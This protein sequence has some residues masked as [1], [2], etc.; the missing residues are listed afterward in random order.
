[1]GGVARKVT[2]G[3]DGNRATTALVYRAVDD[4]GKT[5]DA[6]F[7]GVHARLDM[8]S[9]LPGRVDGLERTLVNHEARLLASERRSDDLERKSEAEIDQRSKFRMYLPS[10][11]VSAGAFG[12]ALLSYLSS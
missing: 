11:I 10:L 2:I 4:L 7:V 6:H 5:M 3:D 12:V 8:L 1:M 9:P